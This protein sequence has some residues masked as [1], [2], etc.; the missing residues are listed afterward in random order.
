MGERASAVEGVGRLSGALDRLRATLGPDRILERPLAAEDIQRRSLNPATDAAPQYLVRPQSTEECRITVEVLG[1]VGCYPHPIGS[2]TT[3]WEPHPIDTDVGL[4]TLGLRTP[5]R[6]DVHERVGY[7][8]AGISVREVDRLARAQ[9]LC[10]VAY[11]DSDGSASVGSM[12]AVACTSGLG[13]GRIQPVEQ[14]VGLTVVT[15]EATVLKTGASWRLGRGGVAHGTPDPTGIFLGSQGWFGVITEVVLTLAPAPFLAARSWSEPWRAPQ[16]LAEALRRGRLQMDRGSVDSLRLEATCAGGAQLAAIEWF[17]RCW[18]PESAES[19][20][21]RCATVARDLG[22]R[23]ARR[24]VESSA[25]R[26]GELPDHDAR[27]SVPPGTHHDRTGREGFLGIEVNVNWGEQLDAV[28]GVF[29][30]LFGA[31][32]TLRLGHRRLGIYPGPHTVAIGVQAMLSGGEATPDMVR[33]AMARFVEPLSALGAVP[34]RPGRLWRE[35]V[36]RQER[37]DPACALIR[38]ADLA[39]RP[40]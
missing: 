4:D 25:G 6:I 36:E 18:A 35:I 37:G 14:I 16:A 2:L 27:Y 29:A 31:L 20:D 13:L 8:G 28:L 1:S 32:G 9:G 5:A 19:A 17:V 12:A 7:F 11:P 23:D 10:L 38:R 21:K 33:G 24:W 30:D 34:Y 26:C 15:R 22:A 39:G 40:S 3:F